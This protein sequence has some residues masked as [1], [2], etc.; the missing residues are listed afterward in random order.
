MVKP[1]DSSM[2][3][4]DTFFRQENLQDSGVA[5]VQL[6]ANLGNDD[7]Q[8]STINV[9]GFRVGLDPIRDGELIKRGGRWVTFGCLIFDY[10]TLFGVGSEPSGGDEYTVN[11]ETFRVEAFD[12]SGDMF[13]IKA[14]SRQAKRPHA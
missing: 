6:Q 13:I 8:P 7:V 4:N 5:Y 3:A 2:F 1:M 11:G 12:P 9:I 14:L 10:E